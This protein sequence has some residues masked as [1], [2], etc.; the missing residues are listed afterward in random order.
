MNAKGNGRVIAKETGIHG[1][2]WDSFHGG[3]FSDLSVARPLIEKACGAIVS[4]Q[5]DVVVDLGGGTGYLLKA[6]QESCPGLTARLV[7]IDLSG[8]QLSESAHECIQT[9]Q[10]PIETFTRTN[11]DPH[12]ERFLFLMRSALHYMG[13]H[14]IYPFLLHLRSQMKKDEFFVH[15]TAC[16]DRERDAFCLNILYQLMDTEKWYL[17]THELKSLLEQSGWEVVSVAPA[18]LLTL[19][20]DDLVKRYRLNNATV[21]RIRDVIV[22]QFGERQDV[23]RKTPDGFCAYLQ[24]RIFTCVAV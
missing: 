7:N 9:V 16:F 5:P 13:K 20:S 10:C 22:R 14:G 11:I 21:N 3:Y 15:Q 19:P 24:Y 2:A 6:L 23:F 12:A 4:S 17:P 1:T 18:P 8:K